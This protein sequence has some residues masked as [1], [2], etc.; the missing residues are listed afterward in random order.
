MTLTATAGTPA[1]SSD[2]NSFL[3]WYRGRVR[4]APAVAHRVA[5]TFEPVWPA[6]FDD[7]DLRTFLEVCY[8]TTRFYR[9]RV[10]VQTGTFVGTSAVAIALAMQDNVSGLLHTIDPEPPGYFGV[11]NPVDVARRVIA[12]GGL[13]HHVQ[14]HRA[15]STAPLDGTRLQLVAAPQWR[16]K[17]LAR[18]SS[19]DVLVVDGDHTGVGCFLD[20]VYGSVGLAHDGPRL[21]VVHDYLGIAEVRQATRRFMDRQPCDLK[22]VPS[23]CGIALLR[24]MPSV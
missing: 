18:R 2:L 23:R 14:F 4:T 19:W 15:Y 10:V 20:L 7:E 5:A 6:P 12:A 13:A 9:P 1:A 21:M 17:E 16:L 11:D 24:L 22:V 3:H 8:Q